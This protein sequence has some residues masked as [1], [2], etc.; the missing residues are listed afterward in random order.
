M[1]L[2]CLTAWWLGEGAFPVLII[3]PESSC[4]ALLSDQSA[5]GA[6]DAG[7]PPLKG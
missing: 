4:V 2:V 3:V 7:R 1:V 5:I 6:H